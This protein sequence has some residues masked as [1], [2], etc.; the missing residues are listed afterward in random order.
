[1]NTN[2]IIKI[3]TL[4]VIK[5]IY[6]YITLKIKILINTIKTLS[7]KINFVLAVLI[8]RKLLYS[9]IRK[10]LKNIF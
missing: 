7:T 10:T 6:N 5:N 2:K 9:L 1:M 8:V 3:L 4:F